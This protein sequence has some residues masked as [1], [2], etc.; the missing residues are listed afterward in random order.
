MFQRTSATTLR[1]RQ[2]VENEEHISITFD[3]APGILKLY[4]SANEP[5]ARTYTVQYYFENAYQSGVYTINNEKTLPNQAISY[6]Q[7]KMF[8]IIF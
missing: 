2:G 6:G 8:P 7:Q 1:R 3:S 5:A 4:Y